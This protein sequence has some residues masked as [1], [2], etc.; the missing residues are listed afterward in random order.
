MSDAPAC[1]D[2]SADRRPTPIHDRLDRAKHRHAVAQARQDGQSQRAAVS[3]AGVARSTLRHWNA[4]PAPSAPAALSAF[5]ETPEGVVWLRRI[6]VA[7]HWSIGEQG[8]AGVRVVCD[9]LERSGL[10]AFIGASYGTQQ[11]FHAGLEEQIVTAATEL[12]GTL[13]QSMP[14]RLLSIAEDETWKDGMRLVCID[15]TSNFILLEQRSD[16]RSA[17]AWTR[18]LEGGLEGLNVTVVQGTSDEAKGLLAHVERDLGAHHATDLFHLQHAVSQAMSL[19][20]KRAEQQAE[21]AEAEAKARWQEECAAEQA[22]HRRRHGPGRPPAFAA[23]IE[24]ALNDHVQASLAREQAHAHRAEAKALIGAFGEVDHPYEIQQGQA[25][26]PEQL[27][28]RL[29]TRLEAIAEEADLS[30]RLRAHLAKAKRLTQSLVA[31]LTFFFMMV[32]TRVQAMDLAP[33][34]EQAMLDDLIPALYLERVAA[35]ST[36]AEPRHRLRALSAQRLAPLRQPSHPIQS[37]DPQTRHHLEQVA[38]EC[39]DLFQR[40]S[41]CVEGRNGFLAL[42]QH[43]HHRLSPRKQQVLTALHNFAIKRPDG[44]TAAERFFA[45]PHPS[46]FEQVLERMPWPARPARRRPRPARPPYLVPVAA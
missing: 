35:R 23:R 25:Q 39:A 38:G 15:A 30:E 19:S 9:F 20:L 11:A 32:N 36:R 18:A 41:S 1:V 22:Y 43:G 28:A 46:L 6:L 21:T 10:S 33:A 31:T 3:G 8:G 16:E 44:T 40:S 2:S 34:I 4:S 45:Q 7:A 29:G 13:A 37:L 42:Y 5:V 24:E 14:H 17:A 27:E 26:T 12:R